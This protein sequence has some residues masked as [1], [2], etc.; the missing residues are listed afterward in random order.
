M[1]AIEKNICEIV[2]AEGTVEEKNILTSGEG[3]EI[4]SYYVEY[5][6]EHYTMTKNDGEWVYFLHHVG[7]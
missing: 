2:L 5:L 6:G 3:I 4:E 1:T 7:R